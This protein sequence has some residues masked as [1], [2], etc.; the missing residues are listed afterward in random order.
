M[1]LLLPLVTERMMEASANTA[2]ALEAR[3][4]GAS[5]TTS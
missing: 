2:L 5:D 1:F 3:A 4:W